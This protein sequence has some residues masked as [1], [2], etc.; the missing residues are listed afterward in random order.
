MTPLLLTL[1]LAAVQPPERGPMPAIAPTAANVPYG[2]HE[3]QVLDF[4]RAESDKPTPVVFLIHG[5]GWVN[6]DK[7]GYRRGVNRYLDAGISVVAINYRMVT[8]ADAAGVKPPVKWPVGDAA[9]AVQ[10]VRSKAKEWNLD[11]T[12]VG[13]TGGSA[14]GCSSLWLA[15]HDDLADPNSADPVARESTRLQCVA[16]TGAQTTLDPKVLREWMPNARYGGHAFAVRTA[17]A[18]D[19]AFQAFFEQREKLLPWI[20]EY[21]PMSHVTKDDPPVFLEYPAQKKPPVKGE[22]QDDPTHS[23]LLGM[24]LME[25]LRAANVEAILVYPGKTHE[26]YKVSADFLIDRLKPR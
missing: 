13:A 23:A 2:T 12:R 4:W 24:I 16:V 9:R 26:K 6:G 11:K 17:N 22:A 20:E 19:G 14:G 18:R 21:S 15:F 5:G 1:T 7:S 8:Q 25:K 10:F 3:R